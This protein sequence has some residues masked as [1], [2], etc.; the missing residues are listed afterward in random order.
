LFKPA[1]DTTSFPTA[2]G[3][4]IGYLVQRA[5]VNE[6]EKEAKD[7][8]AS[9]ALTELA[10]TVMLLVQQHLPRDGVT[11]GGGCGRQAGRQ[12]G[13]TGWGR[14]SRLGQMHGTGERG[15]GVGGHNKDTK[16]CMFRYGAC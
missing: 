11:P 3:L 6:M 8:L 5:A 13:A 12:A 16:P 4:G 9:L 15:R 14:T 2:R 1:T 10:V 7:E